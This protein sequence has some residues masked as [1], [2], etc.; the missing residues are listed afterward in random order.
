MSNSKFSLALLLIPILTLLAT[1]STFAEDTGENTTKNFKD[2][3]NGQD[4]FV[5]INYLREKNIVNG[6]DDHTF[7]PSREIN[8]AE[9]L[10]MISTATGLFNNEPEDPKEKPF[11]DTPLDAW[12][13]KYLSKAKEI[14]I[15]TGYK[16]GA[17]YPE[18]T[19]N[20]AETLKIYFETISKTS[21]EFD[22]ASTQDVVF[23]DTAPDSWYTKYTSYAGAKNIINIYN[24]NNINPEQNMTR[25]YLSEI[26][27]RTVKHSEGYNFGK[28]TYYFGIPGKAGDSYD[29]NMMTTAHKTLPFGT[30]VEVTNL[31]NGK[32]IKVKVTDRGPYGPGRELDLSKVAFAELASPSEGVIKIQYK[33]VE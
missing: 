28:A 31:A 29:L 9:A 14:G 32:S 27:Y 2:V 8:R 33:I 21:A 23:I 13:T 5:A 6:Y 10:K 3:K 26:I 16:D 18:K 4:Y 22:Y 15:I 7:K 17:F 11:I 24:D 25:G 12:Y 19:I 30:I 20:L 1:Q